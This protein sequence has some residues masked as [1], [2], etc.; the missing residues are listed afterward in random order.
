MAQLYIKFPTQ[1]VINYVEV[2]IV[3][4]KI[5]T[6]KNVNVLCN[7]IFKIQRSPNISPEVVAR[8]IKL[9]LVF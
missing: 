9:S 5:R 6:I 3:P 4:G 7:F 8:N 1:I 2:F